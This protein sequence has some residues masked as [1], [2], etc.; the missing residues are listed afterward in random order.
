VSTLILGSSTHA[1]REIPT[2]TRSEAGNFME[3]PVRGSDLSAAKQLRRTLTQTL[4][5]PSTTA[6]TNKQYSKISFLIMEA[7]NLIVP[8]DPSLM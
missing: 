4:E 3:R 1:H 5:T 7:R 8:I 2:F 6:C